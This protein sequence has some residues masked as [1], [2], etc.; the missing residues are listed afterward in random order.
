ML[1]SL[2]NSIPLVYVQYR[3]YNK[4]CPVDDNVIVQCFV[5][6]FLI[7]SHFPSLCFHFLSR[8]LFSL[9]LSLRPLPLLSLFV[10]SPSSLYLSSILFIY[11]LLSS[12]LLSSLLFSY[13][14]LCSTLF[15]LSVSFFL[16]LSI[17]LSR[18]HISALL[19]IFS[20]IRV[21]S[22]VFPFSAIFRNMSSAS[23][24]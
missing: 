15:L 13:L 3:F 24:P 19:H 23:D 14:L 9:S 10:P 16:Y 22:L 20:I 21:P 17:S 11:P 18:T 6:D 7:N 5:K 12:F 1:H 2:S 8:F 4:Q